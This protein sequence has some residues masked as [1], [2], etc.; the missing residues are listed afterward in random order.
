MV[1]LKHCFSF[2]VEDPIDYEKHFPKIKIF[3]LQKYT[4]QN[5]KR[6]LWTTCV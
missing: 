3:H 5:Y 1:R 4:K 2:S 6:F